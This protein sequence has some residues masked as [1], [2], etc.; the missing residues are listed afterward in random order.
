MNPKELISV[1]SLFTLGGAAFAVALLGNVLQY[2][3]HW[4]PRWLGLVVALLLAAVGA[5]IARPAQWYDWIVALF[6]GIQIYATAVGIT[7]VTGKASPEP[8]RGSLSASAT[9]PFW[10]QWF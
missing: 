10:V 2:V 4:N 7:A 5:V 9:R 8:E 1:T 3:F 6:Q